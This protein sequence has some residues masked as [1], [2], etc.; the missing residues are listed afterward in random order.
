MNDDGFLV[1]LPEPLE[2]ICNV[3]TFDRIEAA[4]LEEYAVGFFE[5][6]R[7][8]RWGWR[9]RKGLSR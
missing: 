9:L 5:I 8:C 2:Q 6:N 1:L 4:I 7:G 3:I